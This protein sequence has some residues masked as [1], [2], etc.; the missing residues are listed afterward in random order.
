MFLTID[1]ECAHSSQGEKG[2][3][4]DENVQKLEPA[5]ASPPLS[6]AAAS[7]LRGLLCKDPA[8]YENIILFVYCGMFLVC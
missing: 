8:K 1:N 3:D 4:L 7:L 5:F 2:S 6:A